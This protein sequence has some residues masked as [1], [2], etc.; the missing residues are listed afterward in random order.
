MRDVGRKVV[1]GQR[2]YNMNAIVDL[3]V[4]FINAAG[5]EKYGVICQIEKDLLLD[6]APEW[7]ER[8]KQ[9]M[10]KREREADAEIDKYEGIPC[11]N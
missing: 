6:F 8:R 4:E 7:W 2:S 11:D 3:L 5:D 10:L 1:I 9:E